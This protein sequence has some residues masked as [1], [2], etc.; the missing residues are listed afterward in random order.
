[1]PRWMRSSSITKEWDSDKCQ[2]G[3][4]HGV[5]VGNESKVFALK[6]IFLYHFKLKYYKIE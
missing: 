1:M 2:A 5:K 6:F 3:G 4:R